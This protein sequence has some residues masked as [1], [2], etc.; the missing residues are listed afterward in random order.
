MALQQ[1]RKTRRRHRHGAA[2]AG[3]GRVGL[4]AGAAGAPL[5]VLLLMSAVVALAELG[6]GGGAERRTRPRHVALRRR[7]RRRRS[8]SASGARCGACPACRPSRR[9]RRARRRRAARAAAAVGRECALVVGLALSPASRA[10]GRSPSSTISRPRDIDWMVQGRTW[11]AI[12]ATSTSASCRTTAAPCTAAARSSS[13]ASSAPRSSRC[14]WRRCCGA[15]PAMPLMYWFGRRLGGVPP[16][17]IAALFFITAPE[18]L[19]WARNENIHFAPIADLRAGHRPPGAV[20][21]GALSF[22]AVLVNGAVDAVVPLVLFGLH[23]AFLIPIATAC[24][25][26]SSCAAC[27]ARPGTWCRSSRSASASGSSAS[28]VMKGGP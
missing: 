28:R 20:D 26:W 2:H 22:R 8:R 24:T 27:G 14:A 12:S 21:G 17:I 25:P 10:P 7:R 16:A 19:F 13:S 23:G 15:S 4:I 1:H 3:H 6:A 18:Q 11:S 9:R 5:P